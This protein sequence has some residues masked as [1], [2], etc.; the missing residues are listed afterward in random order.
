MRVVSLRQIRRM[1]RAIAPEDVPI[2]QDLVEAVA[3]HINGLR[4]KE[5]EAEL[6]DLIKRTLEGYT[7]HNRI[8]RKWNAEPRK[9]LRKEFF[10]DALETQAGKNT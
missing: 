3:E 8:L 1:I 7:Q 9:T 2:S 6:E 10:E 5:I 4:G